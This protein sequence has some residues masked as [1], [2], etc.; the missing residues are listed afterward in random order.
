MRARKKSAV[1]AVFFL[2]KQTSAA[3]ENFAPRGAAVF[4]MAIYNCRVEKRGRKNLSR[5]LRPRSIAVFGGEWARNVVAQCRKMRFDGDI[6]FVHPRGETAADA[7]CFRAVSELPHPPD[8]AFVGV[9]REAAIAVVGAL[10]KAGCGGAICFASGFAETG[11]SDLQRRLCDAASDMPLL[12]PNCY[13]FLNLLDGAPLWPDQHGGARTDSGAAIIGQSSNILINISSQTR[14]LPLAYLIAAGNQ[15]QTTIADIGRGVL[16]DERVRALGLYIEGVGDA[17]DFAAF[18]A[19]ARA[20]GIP[21]VALK[22]GKC[23]AAARATE[24]HTAA[25]SGGGAASSAFLR[26]CGIAEARDIPE[27]LETLKAL[28]CG[29]RG[30]NLMSLSCSGGEAAHVADLADG[31]NLFFPPPPQKRREELSANLGPLVSIANP[32]DYHTFIWRDAA[33]LERVYSA[34]LGCGNDLTMLIYDYPRDDRCE[35]SDWETPMRAFMRAAADSDA[36]AA[37]VS[38]LPENMPE[39]V[40]AMLFAAGVAP[41][42][43]LSEALAA[44]EN[45]AALAELNYD[46]EW[47]PL[48]PASFSDSAAGEWT[49]EAAAKVLLSQ[50]GVACPDG[51]RAATPQEA[52]A[53]AFAL[54]AEKPGR[55]FAV[56]TL[57][58]AHK[59]EAGGVRLNVPAEEVEA[60]AAALPSGGGFLVEEMLS[61]GV[62]EL[63]V[64]ARR[65][66]VYG[67][68]LSVGI[69]GANAE[70]FADTRTLVLPAAKSE[71]ADA[72]AR[73][74]LSPLLR[75]HRG[76]PV[77]DMDAA[78]AAAQNIALLL[79]SDDKIAEIEV[80]P[81]LVRAEGGGAAA[82]DAL[83]RKTV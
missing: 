2:Q 28:M 66:E 53:A 63:L 45:A 40:A 30:R 70:V 56:K 3:D 41:L 14:G 36:R 65:D 55:T 10:A 23:R 34:A 50:N 76:A 26:K 75:G 44:L 60:A 27:L 64:G 7:E 16:E 68:T 13:G 73:L 72:F 57:G 37:V 82:A 25:L 24:S 15:A 4:R 29:A 19:A 77:A 78:A 21:V 59:T 33:A 8:V 51:R 17:A 47:R 71:I 31:K 48:P 62:A 18:A 32:L 61:G 69:G 39:D 38:T 20:R 83:L 58:L 22:S 12:G 5:L 54:A 9:N 79:L 6:W 11:A 42:C 46:G 74:R 67:A 43:G 35:R 49:D 80:N 81:L 1:F 52:G